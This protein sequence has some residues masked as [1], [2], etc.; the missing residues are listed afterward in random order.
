MAQLRNRGDSSTNQ[1]MSARH[2]SSPATDKKMS[3][4]IHSD[5]SDNG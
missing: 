2:K 3:D 5:D 1:S 4:V